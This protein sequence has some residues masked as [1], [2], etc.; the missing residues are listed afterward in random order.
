[1][2]GRMFDDEV[3]QKVL[4]HWPFKVRRGLNGE[5]VF[6]TINNSNK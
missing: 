3:V 4:K 6:S 2:V 5:P 1:M